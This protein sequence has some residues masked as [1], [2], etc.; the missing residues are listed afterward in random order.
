M[1]TFAR[2]RGSSAYQPYMAARSSEVTISSVSS[3][4]FR[5][6]V[7]HWPCDGMA[8]VSARMVSMARAR[9]SRRA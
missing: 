3:S 5:R 6:K 8:G 7:P 1:P 2:M 9:W 4:W